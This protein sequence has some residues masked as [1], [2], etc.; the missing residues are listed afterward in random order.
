M[1]RHRADLAHAVAAFDESEEIAR[2]EA[3][4][5]LRS[6]LDP[7]QTADDLVANIDWRARADR[8]LEESAATF[9]LAL[10]RADVGY[11]MS[12]NEAI[13]RYAEMTENP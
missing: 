3:G 12:M 7:Q 10:A 5:L 2:Q 4:A 11:E 8:L 6:V 13:S 1:H 9:L